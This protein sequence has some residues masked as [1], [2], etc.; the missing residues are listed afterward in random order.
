MEVRQVFLDLKDDRRRVERF[1][2]D[3][4]LILEEDVEYTVALL[5]GQRLV[6]TGSLSGYVLK[7]IA[8]DGQHQGLGASSAILTALVKEAASRGHTERF[9]FTRPENEPVFAEQGFYRVQKIPGLVV[10]MEDNARGLESW[11][12]ELAATFQEGACIGAVVVNCNP[13]TL[14]HRYLI[15][16]AA[17]ECDALH[18]F[19]VEEERSAFPFAV[20]YELVREGTEDLA[21]VVLHRGGRYIISGATFPS[22]FLRQPGDALDVHARLD[23]TIFGRRIAPVL[24][25][26]RRYV[27]EEPYCAVT[28]RYNQTM[29]RVLPE[30]DV[31]VREIPR[32]QQGGAAVSASAVR[33]KLGHNDSAGL[34]NLVPPSTL[35]F[36]RSAEAAP[37]IRRLAE[38][39][40]RH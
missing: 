38:R 16:T 23:L 9:L 33:A 13:F 14:G 40:D 12:H 11:L 34:E 15:E 26:R 24:G 36:L 17:R 22:Y 5:D 37:I 4:G 3:R 10:L 25:V 18:V 31:E 2:S 20:R 27:G 21:N 30:L 35:R 8:V 6:G 39:P 28:A 29:K 1:L 19:V 32:L 7:C